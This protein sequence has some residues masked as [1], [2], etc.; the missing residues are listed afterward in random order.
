MTPKFTIGQ[1]QNMSPL[2][3]EILIHYYCSALDFRDLGAPAIKSAINRFIALGL[4]K[5]NDGDE[6]SQYRP[7]REALEI[8]IEAICSVPL[9]ER[10]WVIP[11]NPS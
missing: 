2:E 7:V 11:K 6:G 4:L 5:H 1:A 8:Y 3:V 10:Q 9:P